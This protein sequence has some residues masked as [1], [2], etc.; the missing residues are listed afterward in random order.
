M[1]RKGSVSSYGVT[2]LFLAFGVLAGVLGS[3]FQYATARRVAHQN[4]T[5]S[6]EF[7][8][9]APWLALM[10]PITLLVALVRPI[11]EFVHVSNLPAVLLWGAYIFLTIAQ[12]VPLG[13]L[14]GTRYFRTLTVLV[15]FGV[16]VRLAFFPLLTSGH[17]TTESALLASVLSTAAATVLAVVVVW[18]FRGGLRSDPPEGIIT[19]TPAPSS[20]GMVGALL[21]AALWGTWILG[22][23]FA[24]HYL[25]ANA[26]GIFS[27]GHT[28]AGG[29]LFLTAAVANAYI[30]AVLRNPRSLRPVVNGLLLTVAISV[31]STL[32]LVVLG[33]TIFTHIYGPRYLLSRTLFLAL[34]LSVSL[35][36]CA[37]FVLWAAR[38]QTMR[39]VIG[40]RTLYLIMP[41]GLVMEVA[42]GVFWHSSALAIAMGPG[43]AVTV[44]VVVGLLVDAFQRST[45][46]TAGVEY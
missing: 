10:V 15:F 24:R 21:G 16:A 1:A 2:S 32:G 8:R 12:A 44:G 27:V 37:T 19:G 9:V 5:Q 42:L 20:E 39:H 43:V 38:A 23:V 35:V 11:G 36:S 28:A 34:G 25:S 26:A 30:P 3:G 45:N 4:A 7:G 13:M 33:P 40:Q 46:P 18:R 22:L 29:I 31:V 14:T 41:V 17:Q 6:S